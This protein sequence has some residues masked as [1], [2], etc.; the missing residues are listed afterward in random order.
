MQALKT[1]L[2]S[3]LDSFRRSQQLTEITDSVQRKLVD[4]LA[5]GNVYQAVTSLQ[6]LQEL[7][8]T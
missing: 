3:R 5:D 7:K 4:C 1:E 2:N 6:H 8:E